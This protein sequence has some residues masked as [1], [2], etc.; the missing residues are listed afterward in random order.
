MTTVKTFYETVFS[1][2]GIP[3]H[4]D[5]IAKRI[6][7]YASHNNLIVRNISTAYIDSYICQTVV[8]EQ[9][10]TKPTKSVH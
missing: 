3:T 5:T 4:M 8:F 9:D 2:D 6:N 7:L 1:R 10:P